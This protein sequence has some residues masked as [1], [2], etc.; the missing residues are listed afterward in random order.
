MIDFRVP[1]VGDR[2]WV[3]GCLAQGNYRGCEYS[4]TNL[5]AWSAAYDQRIARVDGFLTAHLRGNLGCGYLWPAGGG[6]LR[7]VLAALEADAAERGNPFRLLCLTPR[8]TEELETLCPG[9]FAFA[10]DRDGFDYLYDI[11][12]LSDLGGRKLH[13]KRNHCNQF[14][15]ANETWIYEDLTAAMLPECLEMDAEWDKRSREREGADEADDMTN[16]KAALRLAADN[17]AALGL[18]GGAIRVFGE[19]VAFTMGGPLSQDTFDVHFEKAYSELQGAFPM[20][21]REFA[22]RVRARH[23]AIV[24]LNR[25]DDMGIEGLRKSKLS[26]YPD[27]M[28]EKHSAVRR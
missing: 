28:V 13:G 19:I 6:D 8:Q 16:E 9:E 5:F 26:Y 4:F 24:Y 20:I 3:D 22:R 10:E 1:E 23:P 18:E 14:E 2:T 17:F 7:G 21:N 27:L 12:K 15:Q 25:E 11:N